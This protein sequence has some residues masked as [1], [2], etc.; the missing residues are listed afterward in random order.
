MGVGPKSPRSARGLSRGGLNLMG[1]S[2]VATRTSRRPGSG[3]ALEQLIKTAGGIGVEVANGRAC[4]LPGSWARIAMDCA[5][6]LEKTASRTRP[7][8]PTKCQQTA[9]A[10]KPVKPALSPPHQTPG[11][12]PGTLAIPRGGLPSPSEPI[13]CRFWFIRAFIHPVSAIGADPRVAL[14]KPST[15]RRGDARR[16][17][18][19]CSGGR[20]LSTRAWTSLGRAQILRALGITVGRGNRGLGS[21]LGSPSTRDARTGGMY[22]RGALQS[23]F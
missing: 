23:L 1:C 7:Q 20:V 21:R 16:R 15:E 22:I 17:G 19:G 6:L 4:D 11:S 5:G 18:G 3:A 2:H 9:P 10:T 8:K 14:S 13:G 12:V